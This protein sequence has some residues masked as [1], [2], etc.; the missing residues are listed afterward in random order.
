[1]DHAPIVAAAVA[2][3]VAS[4]SV[5]CAVYTSNTEQYNVLTVTS[6]DFDAM[7]HDHKYD[8]WF[9]NNLH[10]NQASFAELCR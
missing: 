4:V 9:G 10:C 8:L 5:A 7:L 6:V 2:A 1:M 3:V